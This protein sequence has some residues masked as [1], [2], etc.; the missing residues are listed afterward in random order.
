VNYAI[1]VWTFPLCT[2]NASRMSDDCDAH[3]WAAVPRSLATL[4][5][6]RKS[7]KP[8]RP[9]SVEDLPTPSTLLVKQV[10]QYAE[11]HLPAAAFNHS[12]RVYYYGTAAPFV[13]TRYACLPR[14]RPGDRLAAFPRLEV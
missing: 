3:G 10:I 2:I 7:S 9:V 4:V 8:S 12:M 6:S 5:S 11:H 14:A 13:M 1:G